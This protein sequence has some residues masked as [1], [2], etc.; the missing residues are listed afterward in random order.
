M[1]EKPLNY[2]PRLCI[3]EERAPAAPSGDVFAISGICSTY[4]RSQTK[5]ELTGLALKRL[6]SHLPHQHHAHQNRC[7][8]QAADPVPTIPI[9]HCGNPLSLCEMIDRTKN[10]FT[11][12]TILTRRL[13]D[14][15]NK[16]GKP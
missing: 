8:N 15:Y 4:E 1:P 12:K 2:C 5:N 13:W 9:V 3:P 10:R 16:I 14:G 11:G 7:R 6:R